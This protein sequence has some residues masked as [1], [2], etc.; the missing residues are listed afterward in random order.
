MLYATDEW[1]NFTSENK[2]SQKN[3]KKGKCLRLEMALTKVFLAQ[4]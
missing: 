2:K 4:K 3:L 1:L